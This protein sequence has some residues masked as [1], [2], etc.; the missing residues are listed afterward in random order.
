MLH[1]ARYFFIMLATSTFLIACS[2][3]SI[4][5]TSLEETSA[6][7]TEV[8]SKSTENQEVAETT[9]ATEETEQ[10][11]TKETAEADNTEASESNTETEPAATETEEPS[12]QDAMQAAYQDA[13]DQFIAT[14]RLN[15]EEHTFSFE[16]TN[17]YINI[18]VYEK[19]EDEQAH[20]PLVGKY[21]YM[22][23]TGEIFIQDY[24]TGD[25]I[26]YEE[27]E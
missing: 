14:T 13:V 8:E 16:E 24:L 23:D 15:I 6:E 19:T 10:T 22:F 12:E 7:I 21:R 20:T 18:L 26:P 3:E 17:E 4:E 1:K 2:N 27:T 5:G 9:S 11:E 25:Y